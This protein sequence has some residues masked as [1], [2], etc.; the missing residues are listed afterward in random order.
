MHPTVRVVAI[1]FALAAHQC[2]P[3]VQPL[4][5]QSAGDGGRWV[6]PVICRPTAQLRLCKTPVISKM[7]VDLAVT[8]SARSNYGL[9]Y[10]L[11]VKA[12]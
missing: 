2:L 3:A 9:R 6:T 1:F 12:V 4:H 5:R 7:G 8:N 10:V 11:L